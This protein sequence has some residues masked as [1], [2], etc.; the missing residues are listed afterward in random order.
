MGFV[1]TFFSLVYH[2]SFLSPS[3]WETARY[4]LKYCLKGPLSPKQP[5]NQPN[6]CFGRVHFKF[7]YNRKFDFTAKSL[8]HCRYNEVPLYSNYIST[9]VRNKLYYDCIITLISF[10]SFCLSR[11]HI[12]YYLDNKCALVN[13]ARHH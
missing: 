10:M 1:W 7:P 12:S 11:D 5:T 8:E 4:R 13:Q 3:L 9:F 6:L 2:F